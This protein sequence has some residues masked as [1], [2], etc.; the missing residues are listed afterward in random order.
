MPGMRLAMVGYVPVLRRTL[1]RNVARPSRA[2]RALSSPVSHA[3]R[4]LA[5]P[6]GSAVL[7]RARCRWKC[8]LRHHLH[9]DRIA[10]HA[11]N[12]SLHSPTYVSPITPQLVENC[13]FWSHHGC[14]SIL[15]FVFS[16]RTEHSCPSQGTNPPVRIA[17]VLSVYSA[18]KTLRLRR[19]DR[20]EGH[21]PVKGRGVGSAPALRVDL[22]HGLRRWRR[23]WQ[24]TKSRRESRKD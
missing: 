12:S 5:P 21:R 13:N 22:Q 11:S 18:R 1:E 6:P 23:N 8:A 7:S 16:G 17:L 2:L 20:I 10:T 9:K 4:C 3:G 14:V 19:R 15:I 24:R